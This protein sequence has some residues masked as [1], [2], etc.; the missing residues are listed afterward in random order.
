MFMTWLTKEEVD[1]GEKAAKQLTAGQACV[2]TFVGVILLDIYFI[3]LEG[4]WDVSSRVCCDQSRFLK[5]KYN[6]FLDSRGSR[7]LT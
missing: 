5:P 3:L 4:S 6:L 2:S 1:T 7:V